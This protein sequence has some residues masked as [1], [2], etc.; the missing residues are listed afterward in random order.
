MSIKDLFD[1]GISLKSVKNKTKE[2]LAEDLESSRYV[3]AYAEKRGRFIPN[4]DFTTASNF[5]KFG[6]AEEYYDAA[7]K[8]IYQTYPYD[9]S[10]AEKLEWENN[11]TYLDLFLF[12]NE[13]PR[14]NGFI[15]INS[16]SN[17]YTTTRTASIYSSSLPQYVH[18][19]SGPHADPSGD[20]KS[21]SVAGPSKDG[22]SK[23]NVYDT[24]TNRVGNL[25]IN[26]DTGITIEFW[27]KKDAWAGQTPNAWEVLFSNIT[28]GTTVSDDYLVMYVVDSSTSNMYIEI[29]SDGIN[30]TF[31][32]DTGLSD[33]ADGQ[34]H[35]YAFTAKTA[36]NGT[37][38]ELYVDG[39]HVSDVDVATKSF[40]TVPGPLA[41][42]IGALSSDVDG[43]WNAGWGNTV[44]TSFDEFRYWKAK[45]SAQQI[46]RFY[47]DQIGGGTNTDNDKYND[48]V[49]KEKVGLT[50]KS[51]G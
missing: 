26:I 15:N 17:T 19:Y 47:R 29:N 48:I 12:E 37:E 10:Q 23:A 45:R 40:D 33:I 2:K 11:S 44:E 8:R 1:K 30:H 5:A 41:A 31:T 27:M 49:R 36:G 34:W 22:I 3:D 46:G 14:T 16:G 20:Y 7:I 35:H 13:Y 32:H 38:T 42:A 28:N 50:I 51:V 25:E 9:G 43:F 39:V 18:F 6:L 24:D 4:V 21:E